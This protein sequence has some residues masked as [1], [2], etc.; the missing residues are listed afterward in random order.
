MKAT[1][2]KSGAWRCRV[3][4]GRDEN[5]KQIFK[6]FTNSDKKHCEHLASEYADKYR[7]GQKNKTFPVAAEE[8][9]RL[10]KPVLS[11]KTYREYKHMAETLKAPEN[12]LSTLRCRDINAKHIQKLINRMSGNGNSAKTIKNHCGFISSV[13]KYEDVQMPHYDL[14]KEIKEEPYIPTTDEVKQIVEKAKTD[15]PELYVPIMLAA[16]ASMRRSEI[17]ALRW[18]DDFKGNVV[19][20]N[21]AVVQDEDLN[22]VTKTTKTY[23]STRKV[24]IPQFIVDAIQSQGFIT[25]ANPNQISNEFI[26]L[27]SKTGIQKF[28]FHKLRHFSA[29]VA[30]GM[31]IPLVVVE[32]RGGWEHGSTALLKIYTHVLDEQKKA[33]TN[34][35]NGFF[36]D[37]IT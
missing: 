25:H 8:F 16:F 1:Q 36:A 35:I 9:L 20:I 7:D 3:F 11:P 2:L 34:K 19:T 28:S 4:I 27:V 18:P 21:K 37:I 26:R 5:G 32:D 6:S 13:L 15:K 30:L 31:G 22:W 14:P 24:E 33:E 10:K 29:S 17:C 12:G 23:V